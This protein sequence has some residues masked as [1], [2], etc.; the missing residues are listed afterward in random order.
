MAKKILPILVLALLLILGVAAWWKIQTSPVDS[1]NQTK[2]TFIISNGENV[3]EIAA[4]LKSKGLIRDEWA[5]LIMSKKL[6]IEKN[7]Q[8]GSYRLSKSLSTDQ[9]ARDLTLGTEDEWITIPEGWRS[10]QIIEY[11]LSQNIASPTGIWNEEGKYFPETYLIPKQ[12]SVDDV[13]KLMRKTFDQRAPKITNE[14]LIIASI[15]EREAQNSADR[16]LVASVILNRLNIGMKLDI[17]ATVQ[18]A[19][20][21]WKKDLTIDDLKIKSPY[22]TYLNPGLPPGPICNPG[23][24]SINAVLNPAKT[25]YLYYLTDKNGVTHYAATLDQH[26]AN[27]AKYLGL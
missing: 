12:Y 15:V 8:A 14:Q 5:F 20:G 18:Y 26:N 1:A 24:A 23:I 10:E 7:I 17:D 11:L 22:N 13:R 2:Q 21:F 27:V 4:D 9:I 16:P 25:N 19:L 3:R 6:G